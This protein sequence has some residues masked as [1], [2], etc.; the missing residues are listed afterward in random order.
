[1][2]STEMPSLPAVPAHPDAESMGAGGLIIRH[3]TTR[4]AGNTRLPGNESSFQRQ[5]RALLQ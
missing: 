5:A 4:L 1:M 2:L 3:T